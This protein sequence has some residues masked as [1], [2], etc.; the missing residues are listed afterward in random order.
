MQQ[1][2]N[3]AGI[4]YTFL[5]ER[6]SIVWDWRPAVI[7]FNTKKLQYITTI[8]FFT[9]LY[10]ELQNIATKMLRTPETTTKIKDKDRLPIYR[11]LSSNSFFLTPK[12]NTEKKRFLKSSICNFYLKYFILAFSRHRT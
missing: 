1:I 3:K 6:T 7:R 4:R 9:I 5:H 8:F 2:E 12:K 11:Y 10:K